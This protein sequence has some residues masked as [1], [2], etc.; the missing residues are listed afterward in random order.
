MNLGINMRQ[1]QNSVNTGYSS[2]SI[3]P[4]MGQP[5]AQQSILNAMHYE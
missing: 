1:S 5:D 3:N 4:S 2:Q